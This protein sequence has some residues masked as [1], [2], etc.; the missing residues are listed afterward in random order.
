[1]RFADDIIISARTKVDAE[2][3]KGFIIEFLSVRGL[4]LNEEKT[5]ITTVQEGR[6]VFRKIPEH[7]SGL[8]IPAKLTEQK[9]P[10]E[11]VYEAGQFFRYLIKKYGL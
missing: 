1:M 7:V 5:C 4:G 11:A 10:D 9:L 8:K 3:I 6:V 2:N